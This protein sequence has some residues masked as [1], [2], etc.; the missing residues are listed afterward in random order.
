MR[1]LGGGAL[2]F[3]AHAGL[4]LFGAPE[5]RGFLE[6]ARGVGLRLRGRRGGFGVGGRLQRARERRHE[7]LGD[8][9][10]RAALVLPVH[11]VPRGEREVAALQEVVVE[12]V[13]LLVVADGG[14]LV[15]VDAPSGGRVVMQAR[16]AL[17]LRLLRDVHEELH[18]EVAVVGKLLF[19]VGR[20]G[21]VAAQ[22][23]DVAL[24]A[25]FGHGGRDGLLPLALAGAE[26]QA[27]ELGVQHVL[28][29]GGVP[30][31][32]EERDGAALAEPLPELLHDR[33]EARHA[34]LG[35]RER[36]GGLHVEVL[37]DVHAGR[38][39][40][41][42]VHE[43]GDAAA[44]AGAVP[45]FEQHDEPDALGARLLLQHHQLLHQ[46]V[47]TGFV[48]VFGQRFEREIDGFQHGRI[49]PR[50]IPTS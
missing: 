9:Q 3:L 2:G 17:L 22:H 48:V 23:V 1:G 41:E 45:P 36:A 33:V 18:H 15:L 34:V 38:A 12:P 8:L 39:R 6:G 30:A 21:E 43:V 26:R 4:F 35:A 7:R 13:R 24:V 11:E 31:A 50:R 37:G 16:E 27:A 20:G 29:G 44:L 42:V 47:A 14:E 19:E 28:H 25:R 49:L 32:V 46:L 10:V 5:Q 40:V